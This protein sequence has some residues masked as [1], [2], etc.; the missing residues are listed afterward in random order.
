MRRDTTAPAPKLEGRPRKDAGQTEAPSSNLGVCP[1][2]T[3]YPGLPGNSLHA[4][5][6]PEILFWP[7]GFLEAWG[8]KATRSIVSGK[9]VVFGLGTLGLHQTTWLNKHSGMDT[10]FLSNV[11]LTFSG[12]C[13]P[14]G[15]PRSTANLQSFFGL[16]ALGLQKTTWLNQHFGMPS[17]MGPRQRAR[18]AWNIRE[19][20]GMPTPRYAYC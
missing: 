17:S 8:T 19:H 14:W 6:N 2:I 13:R 9:C 11:F 18:S 12:H 4:Q 5:R 3:G 10:A 20:P 7:S 1:S 15:P 16:G